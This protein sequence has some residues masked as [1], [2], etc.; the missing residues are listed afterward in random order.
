MIFLK[1]FPRRVAS[2]V[3]FLASISAAFAAPPADPLFRNGDFS[4]GLSGWEKFGGG[5]VFS[6][7]KEGGKSFARY[8]KSP[9]TQSDNYHLDQ[10][11]EFA[12]DR[13]Y[14]IRFRYRTEGDLKPVVA[15]STT[16][17]NQ[18][19]VEIL[20]PS[21]TWKEFK[22]TFVSEEA[23]TLRLQVFAGAR[24][25]LRQAFDGTC[26]LADFRSESLPADSAIEIELAL[27]PSKPLRRLPARFTGVNTLFWLETK[28]DLADGKIASLLK[29]ANVGF[30]RYPGGT[31]GQNFD[32]KNMR[33]IDEKRYPYGPKPGETWLDSPGFVELAKKTGA[34]SY[35]VLDLASMY[36]KEPNPGE[37]RIQKQVE[38]ARVWAATLLSNGLTPSCWELGNE[39][40]LPDV[41]AGHVRLTVK[42]YADLCKRFIAAI[43]SVDPKASFGVC[44]TEHGGFAQLG[45]RDKEENTGDA[46][47]P[48]L[49]TAV[50]N[51]V[52]RIILHHYFHKMDQ[53]P[54]R[55]DFGSHFTDWR[56]E[57]AAWCAASGR[58]ARPYEV[59]FTEWGGRDYK[60]ATGY[61]LFMHEALCGFTR[62]GADFAIEW[63]LRRFAA[64]WQNSLL[65]DGK[66]PT[67]GFQVLA[68]WGRHGSGADFFDVGVLPPAAAI[69][70]F[71]KN[72]TWAFLAA[73]KSKKTP[74]SIRVSLPGAPR[75]NWFVGPMGAPKGTGMKWTGEG[76]I[77]VPPRS[78]VLAELE[79]K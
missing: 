40:Y 19:A 46:W 75:G 28:E 3:A 42:T 66:V 68:A 50:G 43:R 1:R 56:R 17:W 72:G 32:W 16:N 2:A 27:D 34:G 45:D 12:A 48:T 73:N 23:S 59:G 70:A 15:L 57:Y 9:A 7:E 54:G 51:D 58:K 36:I 29:E 35:L 71:R 76:T 22:F 11:L 67:L 61:A 26:D 55:F 52:D 47:W 24:G 38:N 13:K 37:A 20:P 64:G 18:G 69:A 30:L 39:H 31:A 10:R 21:S 5:Q 63:P 4:Q 8:L 53:V 74:L 79:E 25:K 60:D 14:T 62:Q 78:L 77:A 33:V 65:F 44:G 49:L 41:Q 6:V